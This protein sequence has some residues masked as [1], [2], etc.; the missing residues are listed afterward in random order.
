MLEIIKEDLYQYRTILL[1]GNINSP[2][3]YIYCINGENG[4]NMLEPNILH[5]TIIHYTLHNITC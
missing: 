5:C 4:Q 3:F 1:S 2:C